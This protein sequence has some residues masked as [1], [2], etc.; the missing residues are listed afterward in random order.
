MQ[1]LARNAFRLL[2]ESTGTDCDASLESCG[3]ASNGEVMERPNGFDLFHLLWSVTLLE[4]IG[5]VFTVFPALLLNPD[6]Y[7]GLENILFWFPAILFAYANVIPLL[8]SL[9]YF[10][11]GDNIFLFSWVDSVLVI[12]IQY[13][14]SMLTPAI[15]LFSVGLMILVA[16]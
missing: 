14:M 7:L 11:F 10:I 16:L 2:Q 3:A 13:V 8:L 9:I 1:H 6:T 12:W 15:F 4:I 5:P